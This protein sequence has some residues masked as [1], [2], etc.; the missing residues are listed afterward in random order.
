MNER[1][2]I[3][4]ANPIARH[5]NWL[6]DTLRPEPEPGFLPETGVD[7]PKHGFTHVDAP[8]HMVRGSLTLDECGLD[9]LCGEAAVVDVSDRVPAKPV[10]ADVL[11]SRGGHVRK[12][13][14][15][16]LRS[17]L[18]RRFPNSSDDYW[19]HSPWLDASGSKWIVERGCKALVIDFPQ[20]YNARDMNGR[21]V[22]NDE[23]VE[24]R[25]VL[26]A[27][28]MHLEH[29]ANLREIEQERVFLIGWPLRLPRADGGPASPVALTRWP[30]ANPRIADLSLPVR[31]DWRGR[32][33]V[34]L[35]KSFETG[36]PV[37]ETGVR[38]EGHSHTHV[39]TPRYLDPA[40]PG[41]ADFLGP[42]LVG[43][44]DVAELSRAREDAAI[45]A[46]GLERGLP[47][48]R[49]SDILILRTGF[50]ER[51]AYDDP[52]WPDRSPW[53]AETA[54]ETIAARGYRVVAADFEIDAGRKRLRGGPA[55]AVDL[56]AEAVLLGRGL[57]LVKHLTNLSTLRTGRPWLAAMPLNLPGAEAAPARVL[58]L[59]WQAASRKTGGRERHHS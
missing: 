33:S 34:G 4:L 11:E 47:H 29:V 5:W 16:I 54:A 23:F 21:L 19:Q 32:V 37:Q 27:R 9:Q 17:N 28:L 50:T 3:P 30:G 31:A 55:R 51:V 1:P 56:A 48:E 38:F 45:D 36:D 7:W 12:G 46:G 26:G 53:L 25:I 10:T 15:V 41:L 13:D 39:L 14:I 43:P 20:D 59:E 44:A 2:V 57:G 22:T 42:S 35:A 52:A 58:G 8:C 49:G 24:H 6:G 40:A 18:H